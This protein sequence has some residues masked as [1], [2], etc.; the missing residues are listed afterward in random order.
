MRGGL[1]PP[2]FP[3]MEVNTV[4]SKREELYKR[5]IESG[6]ATP[7]EIRQSEGLSPIEGGDAFL[8]KVKPEERS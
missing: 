1:V 6:N 3:Y 7:N 5:L 2:L 4:L 8:V